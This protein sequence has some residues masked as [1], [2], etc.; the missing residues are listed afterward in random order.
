MLETRSEQSLD[1]GTSILPKTQNL[2]LDYRQ[3]ASD[4]FLGAFINSEKQL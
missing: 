4:W 3:W 2:D 1:G